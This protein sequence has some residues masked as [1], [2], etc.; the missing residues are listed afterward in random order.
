MERREMPCPVWERGRRRTRQD[1]ISRRPRKPEVKLRTLKRSAPCEEK[2]FLLPDPLLKSASASQ[3]S[4]PAVDLMSRRHPLRRS[5]DRTCSA[6]RKQTARRPMTCRQK[7]AAGNSS[8]GEITYSYSSSSSKPC[9]SSS[10]TSSRRSSPSSPSSL[11]WPCCPPDVVRWL[12]FAACTRESRC[13]SSRIHQHIEKNSVPLKEVLTQRCGRARSATSDNNAMRRNRD[14]RNA[15]AAGIG[16]CQD[17]RKALCCSRFLNLRTTH[18]T[19]ADDGRESL[20]GAKTR[21]RGL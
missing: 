17:R 20:R 8:Q 4:G 18:A 7:K 9:E 3:K 21:S 16:I 15:R 14:A 12:Q 2:P 13:T 6:L 11:S 10:H 19:R 5:N 1:Q